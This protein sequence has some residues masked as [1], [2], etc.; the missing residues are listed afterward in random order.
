VLWQFLLEA[1][2]LS[3][4]GGLIGVLLGVAG[5]VSVRFIMPELEIPIS[6]TAV[7]V[8]LG[9]SALVGLTFGTL[10]ALR[11]SRLNPT[12]ALRYE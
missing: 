9:V 2:I 5:P 6:T 1:M 3:V 10:P 7:L 12:E 11:A 4:G 8:A